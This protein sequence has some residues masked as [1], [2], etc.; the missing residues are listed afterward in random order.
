[1]PVLCASLPSLRQLSYLL[2]SLIRQR[3]LLFCLVCYQM[4]EGSQTASRFQRSKRCIIWS[5]VASLCALALILGLAIGLTR[6]PQSSS[7]SENDAL[8]NFPEQFILSGNNFTITNQPST[9]YYEFNITQRNGSPDG[10]ERT[11]LVVNSKSLFH[12]VCFVYTLSVWLENFT[13]WARKKKKRKKKGITTKTIAQP[14]PLYCT[15]RPV[16]WTPY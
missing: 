10:F 2:E 12:P 14:S 7:S 4:K 1:M 9:R 16:P 11:M 13:R 15:Y 6:K 3:F 5:T 8:Q